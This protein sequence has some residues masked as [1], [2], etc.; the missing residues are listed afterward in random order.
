MVGGSHEAETD[1]KAVRGRWKCRTR[2]WRTG[3]C[4]TKSR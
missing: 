3:K 1:W 2:K 4:R